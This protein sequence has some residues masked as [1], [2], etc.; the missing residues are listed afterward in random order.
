MARLP[1]SPL[2]R[3]W[4]RTTKSALL[5]VIALATFALV[6]VRGWCADSRLARVRLAA[7][8]ERPRAEK[9]MLKEEIWIKDARIARI[10]AREPH[11]PPAERL[12]ILALRASRGWSLAQVAERFLLTAATVASWMHRLD[13]QGEKALVQIPEPVNRFPDFVRVVVQKLRTT[14]P[15]MGKVRIA[16]VLA[17]AELRLGATTVRRMMGSAQLRLPSR[18]PKGTRR[19]R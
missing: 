5:H 14:A 10:S 11:Y 17:R 18:K 9:A 13:E 12:S 19:R 6:R 16:E 7:E 4:P 2:P 8:V 15:F 3:G 1:A